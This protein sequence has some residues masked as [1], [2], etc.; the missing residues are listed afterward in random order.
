MIAINELFCD[1]AISYVD[2]GAS[3]LPIYGVKDG[4]CACGRLD[5]D[6]PAKH[7]H[8]RLAPHGLKN[9]TKDG[10]L[11]CQWSGSGEA[12]NLGILT[13][14]ESGLVV[15]DVDPRHGAEE[16]LKVLGTLPETATVATGGGGKHLYFRWP[17]GAG[18]RNSAGKLGPGLDIRGAGGYVVAPPSVHI[19]GGVY[20]WLRDPRGGIA[21]LPSH[22]LA[23]LVDET[24][25]KAAPAVEGTIR[26]G[27]RHNSLTSFAGTMRH[28]GMGEPAILAALR[29]ENKRCDP[30]L[31]DEELQAIAASIGKK[32]PASPKPDR[33]D[34][35]ICRPDYVCMQD[36]EAKP[37]QW[38]WQDRLPS[39]MLSL[40]IGVEG[41][42]K[43]FIGLDMAA[44][45]TTGR[46]WPDAQGPEDFPAVGNVI[47]LT[48]EDHLAFTVRPRLDA[49]K[50]DPSKVFA[51]RGVKW[52]EGEEFFDVV[53]HL[54]AL[55]SMVT[56]V[57]NVKLILCD[58]LTAFLGTTDQHKNGEVRTALIRF[59][60]LAER[61]GCAVV[62][63]SHLNK[64]VNKAA[65]HRTIGSVAF[66]AAAR[67]VWLVA[68]DKENEDRRIF[69]PVKCN[70]SPM[71]KSLAFHIEN[72]GVVWEI[73]EFEI[74]ANELLAGKGDDTSLSEATQF[75]RDLLADGRMQSKEIQ[76][77]AK[78]NGISER[79]LNRAKKNI[80]GVSEKEGIGSASFW[81]WR[82]PNEI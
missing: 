61:Y 26:E 39:A 78:Q 18:I 19:S 80:R 33:D 62:G 40:L 76:R 55:E 6:S 3:V 64:D 1:A 52:P 43:T 50:A 48:S 14:P 27:Q 71:A 38:L 28:R 67:A 36:V 9:A 25:S 53:K 2:L 21:E 51:L 72:M 65:I 41:K 8:G 22:I 46:P 79:T 16:S 45:I 5:C 60:S 49:M 69:C 44:R 59:S 63:I 20:R 10:N 15:L 77:L 56:A 70:L 24:A 68:E 73:G 74:D 4:H 7:P 23:K 11:I 31:K 54:P 47:F 75:L 29:E 32:E 34:D 13:G 58:P 37:L 12:V 30:P 66:S 81:Y 42:G 17:A 82:L 57:G 35:S